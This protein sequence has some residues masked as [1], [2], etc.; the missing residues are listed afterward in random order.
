MRPEVVVEV[1]TLHHL[2]PV[3]MVVPV[4]AAGMPL[5]VLVVLE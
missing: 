3:I 2:S 4:V 1:V 5:E